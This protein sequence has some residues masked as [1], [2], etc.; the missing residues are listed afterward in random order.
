MKSKEDM[1]ERN[2]ASVPSS[3]RCKKC[4]SG[5][6]RELR[7]VG[8]RCH[9]SPAPGYDGGDGT[10]ESQR[11]TMSDASSICDEGGAPPPIRKDTLAPAPEAALRA[12]LPFRVSPS[13]AG[14]ACSAQFTRW[15]RTTIAHTL[16]MHTPRGSKLVECQR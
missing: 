3:A 4:F 2:L 10:T 5:V 14:G 6:K 11:T 9:W 1:G 13:R 16:D 8:S 12:L 15:E 7:V